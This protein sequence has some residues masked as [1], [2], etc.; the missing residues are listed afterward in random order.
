MVL[1]F[2]SLPLEVQE[3]V[4][5]QLPTNY[6]IIMRSASPRL[7]RAYSG[8]DFVVHLKR[9][10]SAELELL[11][12]SHKLRCIEYGSLTN[13]EF[14]A[15]A[16]DRH[17]VTRDLIS[18]SYHRD[19]LD[20]LIVDYHQ[21]AL[22][23]GV[24][25]HDNYS[26]LPEWSHPELLACSKKHTIVRE[27]IPRYSWPVY[28]LTSTERHRARKAF[29]AVSIACSLNRR[30]KARCKTTAERLNLVRRASDPS[31]G[32]L[33]QLK[34]V[35]QQ[36]ACG[37]YDY[38]Y[39]TW[40]AVMRVTGRKAHTEHMYSRMYRYYP[41]GDYGWCFFCREPGA[42]LCYRGTLCGLGPEG[43]WRALRIDPRQDINNISTTLDCLLGASTY[44]ALGFSERRELVP[45][46]I[47]G[48]PINQ[49]RYNSEH[50]SREEAEI[51]N[52]A[53]RIVAK[54][55]ERPIGHRFAY[56]DYWCLEFPW[57][58]GHWETWGLSLWGLG[59]ELDRLRFG[60]LGLRAWTL[61][62][63]ERVASMGWDDPE[64]LG[65]IALGEAPW[66]NEK[67]RTELL[68]EARCFIERVKF[69]YKAWPPEQPEPP[70]RS[71]FERL[72]R[73]RRR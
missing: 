39:L 34:L 5:F 32:F 62:D 14:L 20:D 33:P 19:K 8:D 65:W 17:L 61:W 42:H 21:K 68:R 63:D 35:E 66:S 40:D 60:E 1:P 55:R 38:M 47:E 29:L 56:G 53:W 45:Q 44:L 70:K 16:R 49:R 41:R 3:L 48:Y 36:T 13:E 69:R 11:T 30:M 6:V 9:R 26:T 27:E 51:G 12:V 37:V 10:L 28:P 43:L 50:I 2:D 72:M 71:I 22:H 67:Q 54:A 18:M 7:L 15:Y 24:H 64:I 23:P 52:L 46:R 57:N 73:R 25:I 59:D 31:T 4:L 58:A